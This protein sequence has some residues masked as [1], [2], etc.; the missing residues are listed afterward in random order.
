M[1]SKPRP[2]ARLREFARIRKLVSVKAQSDEEHC[3]LCASDISNEH[4]HLIVP[5]NLNCICSCDACALL[6]DSQTGNKFRRIPKGAQ[7]LKDF[8]ISDSQWQN[9]ELPVE[10]VFIYKNSLS[11]ARIALYPSPAGAMES[12]VSAE[13]WTDLTAS[14][15]SIRSLKDDVEALLIN[16]KGDI[17]EYYRAPIDECFKLV[18]ILRT[19]W[20]GF[21]GGPEVWKKIDLFFEKMKGHSQ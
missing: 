1:L 16:R 17:R 12:F 5:G 2:L 15:P 18:G 3:E 8:A 4:Q 13:N 20:H 14:N 21:G 9:L 10:L 7:W 19:S 11:Q 6:F